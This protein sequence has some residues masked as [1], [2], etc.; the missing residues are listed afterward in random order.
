MTFLDPHLETKK[1]LDAPLP[2]SYREI[3]ALD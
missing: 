1:Y 2:K 3:G